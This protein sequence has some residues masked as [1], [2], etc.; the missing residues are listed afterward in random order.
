MTRTEHDGRITTIA[1]HWNGKRLNSPN[2]AV[3]KSDGSIWFSDPSYGIDSD[4]EGNAASSE[5]GRCNVCRVDPI[6]GS[7]DAVI[8]DMVRPNGLAFSPDER[9]LY[10]ADSARPHH[11]QKLGDMLRFEINEA[12]RPVN[13]RVFANSTSGLFDG[14]RLDT[15]GR[16]WT[17]AANGV[18]CYDADGTLLGR[19]KV[20]EVVANLC[21]GGAKFNVLYICG[22]TSLYG[23]RLMVSGA[24]WP[25][26]R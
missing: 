20:P 6:D 18:H 9:H 17:S 14:F 2:D 15:A 5:I 19:I 7:V 10:V 1:S 25:R 4:Y 11:G 21:F 24:R 12:G 26:S 22:T 3:V 16:I 8:T 13:G 23:V